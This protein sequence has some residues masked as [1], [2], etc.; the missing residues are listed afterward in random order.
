MRY[1]GTSDGL[2]VE[3][4]VLSDDDG[5]TGTAGGNVVRSNLPGGLVAR[6]L[7]VGPYERLGETHA[8]L[9]AWCAENGHRLSGVRWEIYGH[10]RDDAPPEVDVVAL[11]DA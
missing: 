6:M 7:H 10:W 9:D 4:G 2:D 8:T 3:V 11:L 5:A 1:A